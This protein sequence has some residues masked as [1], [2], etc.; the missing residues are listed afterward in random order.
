MK[1]ERLKWVDNMRG[2]A[3]VL[4]LLSHTPGTVEV[5]IALISMFM[6]P[7]FFLISGYLTKFDGTNVFSFFY[8]RIVKLFI[9]Y[10]AYTFLLPFLSFSE[11]LKIIHNPSLIVESLF[12]AG[13]RLLFGEAIWFF[14]CLI[15]VNI[16]FMIIKTISKT[17]NILLM[18]ISILVACLGWSLSFIIGG[19]KNPWSADTALVCQLYFT[20]GHVLKNTERPEWYKN[21]HAKAI[22]SGGIYV[23]AVILIGYTFDFSLL[24]MDVARNIWG[25]LFI[26]LSLT[27]VCLFSGLFSSR[28]FTKL[29]LFPYFGQNSLLYL[30]IGNHGAS[31]MN[32]VV[33]LL[34]QKT[35][36]TILSN[37]GI[38]NPVIAFLGAVLLLPAC[39][40]VNKY[41]PFFNGRFKMPSISRH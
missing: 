3:V 8:N 15:V 41:A 22:I 37:R 21:A 6:I 19:Q 4:V 2:L 40:L 11:N 27:L 10:A 12:K 33:G 5:Q 34:Y 25:N 18:A 26:T 14:A 29:R 30:A 31:I 36:F 7:A 39:W 20:I 9:V 28:I 32:K 1:K 13:K 16:I 24:K 38:I 17:N 23:L 35:G